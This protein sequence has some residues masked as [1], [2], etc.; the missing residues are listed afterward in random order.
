MEQRIYTVSQE[1]VVVCKVSR[2]SS[3]LDSL[4]VKYYFPIDTSTFW[5]G[6]LVAAPVT[7][8]GGT[9]GSSSDKM[10]WYW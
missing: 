4:I 3:I 1:G 8:C 6:V 9:G 2:V 7:K 5:L 10:W